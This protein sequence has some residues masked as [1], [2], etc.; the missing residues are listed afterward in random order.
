MLL[1][2]LPREIHISIQCHPFRGNLKYVQ[3][4][5]KIMRVFNNKKF[6]S[7]ALYIL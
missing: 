1:C 2:P 4:T 3:V 5:E 7:P 6:L